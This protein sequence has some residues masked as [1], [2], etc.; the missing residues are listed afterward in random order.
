MRKNSFSLSLLV[1]LFLLL[2]IVFSAGI[3]GGEVESDSTQVSLKILPIKIPLNIEFAGERV[4]L[5][6]TDVKERMDKELTVNTY[7]QS[8]SLQMFKISPR[9]FPEI[10]KILKQEGV[11]A[12]FKYSVT[13]Q[14]S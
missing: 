7:W 2:G 9:A 5:E 1:S 6:I 4:P 8:N 14:G 3:S 10:E 12:D 13:E 11:P